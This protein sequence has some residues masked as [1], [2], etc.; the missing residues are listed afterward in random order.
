MGEVKY[1][2]P[3][4]AKGMD[5]DIKF[6]I[7]FTTC[8]WNVETMMTILSLLCN[9]PDI[10]QHEVDGALR[11]INDTYEMKYGDDHE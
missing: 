8:R 6:T 2:K 4:Y 7:S 1:F 5:I 9:D 3:G 10:E 11:Y